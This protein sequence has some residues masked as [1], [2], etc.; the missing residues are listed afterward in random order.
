MA[1]LTNI[2]GILKQE[3]SLLPPFKW[4]WNFWQDFGS[5]HKK[6]WFKNPQLLQ[7]IK[8]S[9][10]YTVKIQHKDG[11]FDEWYPNER[12]WAGPTSYVINALCA[13]YTITEE[14]L[15][16]SLKNS[17]QKS[18]LKAVSFLLKRDE[19][20]ILSNHF[21]LFLLS[22][23]R[24]HQITGDQKLQIQLESHL[25]KFLSHTSK[26]GWSLEYNG[27]D[28][29]YELATLGFLGKNS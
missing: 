12:G 5:V 16:D 18:F 15:E 6:P 26:E 20:D 1:V 4:E 3:T 24:V 13:A 25:E 7:W 8:A 29:G 23:H 14:C 11:S 10:A 19:G 27:A 17:L 22:L 21:A 28:F 9:L 2:T